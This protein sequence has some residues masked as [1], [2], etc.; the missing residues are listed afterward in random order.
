MQNIKSLKLASAVRKDILDMALISKASHIGSALSIVDIL[1]VLYGNGI[2]KF[3][4]ANPKYENRDRLI[5]SKGH[6]C[7]ALYATL[8]ECKFFNKKNLDQYGSNNSLLMAHVS[9]KVPGVE[10]STGSLG[11]G[12][13]FGVGLALAGKRKKNNHH[14]FVIN[15]DGEMNEGSNWEAIMFAAHHNLNNLI[16]VIDYNNLQSFDTIE[17]TLKLEPLHNKMKAF[18]WKVITVDG[19]N[20]T[21]LNKAFKKAKKVKIKPI[22]IIA[23]TIKGKGVSFMENSVMWHYKSLDKNTHSNA[24][25]EII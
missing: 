21:D 25:R 7:M 12:L 17:T 20:H 4:N 3:N 8:A 24:M 13:S 2:L 23:N 6:A 18:G 14:V 15:S 22:C 11:H 9:H 19:H 10:F 16:L 5:L 1:S